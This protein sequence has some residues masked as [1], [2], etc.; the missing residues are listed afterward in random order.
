MNVGL[1]NIG[2]IGGTN[3]PSPPLTTLPLLF[4]ATRVSTSALVAGDIYLS[5]T[6]PEF[7]AAV[8]HILLYK[9]GIFII[10]SVAVRL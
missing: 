8:K 6:W 5:V 7:L 9:L 3:V 1:G 4:V 10:L 2:G